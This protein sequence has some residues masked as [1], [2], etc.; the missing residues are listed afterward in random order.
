VGQCEAGD[1]RLGADDTYSGGWPSGQLHA[2]RNR[3]FASFVGG[4]GPVDF[5]P[6]VMNRQDLLHDLRQNR[7]S[8]ANRN[9][10]S[11]GRIEPEVRGGNL[12][13]ERPCAKLDRENTIAYRRVESM[14]KQSEQNDDRDWN[15]N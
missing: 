8:Y 11:T 3:P 2:E 10:S 9:P 14:P 15:T 4:S 12:A 13:L 1:E 6:V 5:L 7:P